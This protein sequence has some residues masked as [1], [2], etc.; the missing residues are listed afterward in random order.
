M[1]ISTCIFSLSFLQPVPGIRRS[2][3]DIEDRFQGSSYSTPFDVYSVPDGAPYELPRIS[4]TTEN[5][6]SILTI[7]AQSAQVQSRFDKNYSRDF[8][9]SLDYSRKQADVLYEAVS[10]MPD[11]ELGYSGVSA[12]VLVHPDEIGN[13]P[14]DFIH[15]TYL[16]ASSDLHMSDASVKLVYNVDR[17]FYLNLEVQRIVLSDPLSISVNSSG[18]S[19]T[20]RIV[21]QPERLSVSVDFNDRLAF[22]EGRPL[23]CDKSTIE[24]LY[25][26]VKSFLTSGLDG[27]LK[28]GR[29][30]F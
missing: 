24:T 10:S 26:R 4:S 23:G 16:K 21:G 12:Q 6:H 15:D 25:G 5:G 30:S 2:A 17:D 9:K 22:N 27:F 18:V 11:I 1:D 28:D 3:F 14:A 29:V 19:V 7:S 20:K 13:N 8:E